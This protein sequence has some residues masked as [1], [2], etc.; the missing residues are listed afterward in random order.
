MKKNLLQI[1]LNR[2]MVL[3]RPVEP[4][5]MVFRKLVMGGVAPGPQT[6]WQCQLSELTAQ[7]S[8]DTDL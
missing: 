7:W 8:R 5:E 3:E 4:V 6:S 1:T 2:E